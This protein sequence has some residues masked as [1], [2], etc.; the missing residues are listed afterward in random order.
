[1]GNGASASPTSQSQ[2]MSPSHQIL[3]GIAKVVGEKLGA[4]EKAF[5]RAYQGTWGSAR[6]KALNLADQHGSQV[7]S[8][9]PVSLAAAP[10]KQETLAV[11]TDDVS[12]LKVARKQSKHRRRKANDAPNLKAVSW[13]ATASTIAEKGAQKPTSMQDLSSGLSRRSTTEWGELPV[14]KGPRPKLAISVKRSNSESLL[15]LKTGPK[16]KK[17]AEASIA[18]ATAIKAKP[19]VPHAVVSKG[20]GGARVNDRAIARDSDSEEDSSSDVDTEDI[21]NPK[22]EDQDGTKIFRDFFSGVDADGSGGLDREEFI[23]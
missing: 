23:E 19:P 2:S 22:D 10:Q 1:M 9:S 5:V 14:L 8:R 3:K 11:V 21:D 16:S 13:E 6:G 4:K 7:A 18:G 17:S 15:K 20:G 12:T